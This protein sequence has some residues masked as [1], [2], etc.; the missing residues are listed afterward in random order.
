MLRNGVKIIENKE[1]LAVQIIRFINNIK[2]CGK[3][4][5]LYNKKIQFA[6]KG[7]QKALDVHNELGLIDQIYSDGLITHSQW[8]A[9]V[10]LLNSDFGYHV[11]SGNTK[12]AIY[13]YAQTVIQGN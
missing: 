4:R 8:D 6:I 11:Y 10:C 7:M 2:K 12:T 5:H 9:V 3:V 13:E 1:E